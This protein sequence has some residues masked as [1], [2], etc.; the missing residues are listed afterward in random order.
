VLAGRDKG[1]KGAVLEVLPGD[2]VVVESIKHVKRHQKPNPQVNKQGGIIEKAMPMRVESGDLQ[3]G[4]EES[5]PHRIQDAHRRQEGAL[6]QVE[7]RK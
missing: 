3:S 6:L 4:F 2:Q 1:R 5:G 7:W